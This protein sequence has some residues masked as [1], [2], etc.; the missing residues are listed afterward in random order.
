LAPAARRCA[1]AD[2]DHVNEQC[3]V[4][5]MSSAGLYSMA[6]SLAEG[7][8]HSAPA[9]VSAMASV[10]LAATAIEAFLNEELEMLARIGIMGRWRSGIAL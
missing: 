9:E 6:R 7:S 4:M 1:L 5:F 3:R 10:I 8:E 2:W